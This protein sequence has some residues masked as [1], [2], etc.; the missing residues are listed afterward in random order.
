[1]SFTYMNILIIAGIFPPDIGGPAN[2]LPRFAEAM[3][4]KNHSI[5]VLCFTESNQMDAAKSYDLTLNYFV[6]RIIRNR[7]FLV[8]ELLTIYFGV[9]MAFKSDVIFVNGNDFKALIIGIITG[10][11]RVHKIVGDTAW[12]R[13]QNRKWFLGTIDEFQLIRKNIFFDLL[14]WLR[15]YPLRT[16]ECIIT[17]S[18]YLKKV[19][20][21]WG[22][23]EKKVNVIYNSFSP[24]DNAKNYPALDT[25]YKWMCTVCRLV[26]WK[27]VDT[28]IRLLLEFKDLGLVIVGDGPLENDLKKL[29]NNINVADRVHFAGMQPRRMVADFVSAAHFFILNSSYEGLPHVVL[30]AMSLR[31]LVVASAVGG[32]VEVIA[33]GKTGFLFTYNDEE[34]IKTYVRK[35]LNEDNTMIV[36]NGYNWVNT[37]FSFGKMINEIESVFLKLIES[38]IAK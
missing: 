8:R 28:L 35:S 10:K 29:A 6:H 9:K 4:L 37:N 33:H 2:F 21:G 16:S 24:L 20:I 19:V 31:K 34:S 30:E 18:F 14:R 22:I 3:V 1:M 12:E 36:E 17:P 26:P 13:A 11:R 23:N 27:G 15:A 25:R 38:K 7:G 5:S 32:T